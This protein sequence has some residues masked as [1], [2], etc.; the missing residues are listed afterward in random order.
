MSGTNYYAQGFGNPTGMYGNPMAPQ[1]QQ[2]H[3]LHLIQIAVETLRQLLV[4]RGVATPVID[5]I[6]RSLDVRT[7]DPQALM[8]ANGLMDHV[9][10]MCGPINGVRPE[11]L[12]GALD[13]WAASR[14]PAVANQLGMLNQ[15]PAPGYQPGTYGGQPYGAPA[16]PYYAQQPGAFSPTNGMYGGQQRSIVQPQ[17]QEQQYQPAG[18]YGNPNAGIQ[19]GE[20]QQHPAHQ[21]Q[22]QAP[23]APASA[24]AP[25]QNYQQQQPEQDK[26][27]RL[28]HLNHQMAGQARTSGIST[29]GTAAMKLH[30]EAQDVEYP[31]GDDELRDL[32]KYGFKA[33]RRI[34]GYVMGL[35][36]PVPT[37][38]GVYTEAGETSGDLSSRERFMATL[39]PED[40][41]KEFLY[42][43]NNDAL[44]PVALGIE[45]YAD[46]RSSFREACDDSR[47]TPLWTVML[48]VIDST[49]MRVARSY[50]EYLMRR[51]NEAL[52]TEFRTFHDP[53]FMLTLTSF[54]EDL[55]DLMRGNWGGPVKKFDGWQDRLVSIV[56]S[57]I[58]ATM[59]DGAIVERDAKNFVSSVLRCHDIED[60]INGIT[61]Y[62]LLDVTEDERKAYLD[63]VAERWTIFSVESAFVVTNTLEVN[64]LKKD[65]VDQT[66]PAN[67][68]TVFW[69][70]FNAMNPRA[71]GDAKRRVIRVW[72]Y[73]PQEDS[74]ETYPPLILQARRFLVRDIDN[75]DAYRLIKRISND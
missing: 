74:N 75:H 40:T 56:D 9:T 8:N 72:A 48:Q 45:E 7:G 18:I 62:D 41:A 49:T 34:A 32:T 21:Q 39:S 27:L 24:V 38:A 25:Q 66:D 5:T 67:S 58:A 55:S 37:A 71:N 4:N 52:A 57:I 17:G 69:K 22:Q 47:N 10:Q 23:Y 28:T 14:V 16:Q 29:T 6:M 73:L 70:L 50:G 46:L 15:Q 35:D 44:E 20:P 61:K 59:A 64:D 60:R 11:V 65:T 54:P 30:I 2:G 68:V 51:L 63:E 33:K 26:D 1:Q 19:Q 13:S 31:N 42:V 3:S 43:V 53:N 12:S 36:Q